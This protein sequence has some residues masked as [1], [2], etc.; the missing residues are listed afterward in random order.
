MP[1]ILEEPMSRRDTMPVRLGNDAIEAA[2]KAAALKGQTL[3]EYAT[4]V[5]LE[6]ANHDIDEFVKSRSKAPRKAKEEGG[7]K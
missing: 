3:T 7:S 5:L 6:V 2:K 1:A 4:R